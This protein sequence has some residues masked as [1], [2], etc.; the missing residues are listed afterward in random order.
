MDLLDEISMLGYKPLATL[1]EYEIKYGTFENSAPIKKGRYQR[2]T[3]RL[4]Y[5]SHT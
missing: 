3:G 1:L 4:I 2:L 5:L